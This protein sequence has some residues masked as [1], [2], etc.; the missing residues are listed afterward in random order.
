MDPVR[1]AFPDLD[2]TQLERLDALAGLFRDW[3]ARIN[4]V[5]RKDIDAF[6]EHHLLHALAL[7][8]VLDLPVGVRVLDVGT[9]GGLPGLPLAILY[10][11]TEFILVDSVGKKIDAVEQMAESLGLTNVFVHHGRVEK[12]QD[13]FAF[14]LGRAVTALPRFLFWTRHLLQPGGIPRCPFGVLYW[15]GDLYRDELKACGLRPFMVHPL[16]RVY[17]D[18]PYFAGKFLIHLDARAVLAVK[19]VRLKQA[20]QTLEEKAEAA[21]QAS[22][23]TPPP[24]TEPPAEQA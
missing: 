20:Q 15:K 19:P 14:V 10:P 6:A 22:S 23:A 13:K 3:N 17:P 9:G 2:P 5:S 8:K 11:R 7:A 24:D 21:K 12:L 16:D 4:L 18:R 1:T